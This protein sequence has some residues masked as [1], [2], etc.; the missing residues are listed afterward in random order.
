ML[1]CAAPSSLQIALSRPRPTWTSNQTPFPC[2]L[3][4]VTVAHS[5]PPCLC[6]SVPP[7]HSQRGTTRTLDIYCGPVLC[8]TV[9]ERPGLIS[10]LRS[11]HKDRHKF[12]T[13]TQHDINTEARC[14]PTSDPSLTPDHNQQ[15][16]RVSC[17]HCRGSGHWGS[18]CLTTDTCA[19]PAQFCNPW[20]RSRSAGGMA[21]CPESYGLIGD[22]L[23]NRLLYP[24]PTVPARL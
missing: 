21:S 5:G 7:H 16:F 18:V 17:A 23:F 9:H 14:A 8:G 22:V 12:L 19:V 13:Y 3:C 15:H 24:S 20:T 1:F 2:A 6:V 4:S 11:Q 10:S